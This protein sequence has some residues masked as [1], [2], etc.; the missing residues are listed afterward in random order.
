MLKQL[1]R[2]TVVVARRAGFTLLELQISLAIMAVGL[3][4]MV[5][6]LAVQSRQINRTDGW[7]RD[8][9]TY[10]VVSQSNKWMR[11]LKAP[12]EI[13][14]LPGQ[15]SWAPPV[16]GRRDYNVDLTSFEQDWSGL[17][18]TGAVELNESGD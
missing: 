7:C 11:K 6:V 17:T 14:S 18:T 16:V 8:E 3:L 13:K 15:F 12:A 2:T 10:Y 5:T 9:P 1:R 4:S